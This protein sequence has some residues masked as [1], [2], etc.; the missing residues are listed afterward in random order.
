MPFCSSC[1]PTQPCRQV[2]WILTRA[3][4][5]S[6]LS[7]LLFTTTLPTMADEEPRVEETEKVEQVEDVQPAQDVQADDDNDEVS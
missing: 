1:P 7:P 2:T 5:L 4:I 6:S 3:G